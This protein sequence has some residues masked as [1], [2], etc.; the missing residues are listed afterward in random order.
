MRKVIS[1]V[2][3]FA[4]LTLT[5]CGQTAP[6]AKP[7]QDGETVQ[8]APSVEPQQG[9][10]TVQVAN[11]WRSV[12]EAEAK[13][14]CP[15]S[16][17]APDGAENVQWRAMESAEK[18]ALVQLSFELT[19]YSYT[20]REQVTN[21]KAADISGMHYTW[22]AQT[23]MT[24]Q[25]WEESAKSGTYYRCIGEGEWADLCAWY[26]TAKGISYSLGVTAK[27]LDGFDLEAIAEM[28]TTP[29]AA[30]AETGRQD[31][32]RFESVIIL[33]GME[34][35]VHYEHIRNDT[36]GFEMDYDYESFVRRKDADR[37]RFISVWDDP[38]NPENYLEV[39]RS[40][41]D[42]ETAAAEICER[43]SAEYEVRRD[44]AYT[45][46][47][48]GSCILIYADEVKG[49]GY[50]PD[51]LQ[52]VYVIPAG[53]GCCIATEHSYIVESE[54]FGR[55]FRYMMDTLAV[56]DRP[57][58]EKLSDEQALAAVRRY[59]TVSNPELESIVNAGEYQAYWAIES[60]DTQK[61][62]VL[63]RSYTGALIRYYIDPVSGETYVTE[64]VSGITP[65]EQ[66][67]GEH[68]NARDFLISVP[69]TWQTASVVSEADGTAHPEYYV[70]FTDPEILYGHMR[71][72]TFVVDHAETISRFEKT[73][74]GGFRI[75]AE[76]A[77][78]AQ[79]TFQTSE[80]D[81]GVLEYFETWN[82]ADFPNSYRGGAS[83]SRCS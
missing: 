38:E 18:P 30:P 83:L 65:E 1:I 80:S 52:T 74:A 13:S 29:P 40:R 66:R 75:R 32:E 20:A 77:D 78:G 46:E 22:T 17:R 14:L 28:L 41:Q 61:I 11:P 64:F 82:E 23:A 37:E 67:T 16:L 10:E 15:G 57:A 70:R 50:M 5:A 76:A 24:L 3:L 68:F 19:G 58:E 54:G 60:S 35:T 69:G 26:D 25:N 45:L 59:C 79:Y 6:S 8:A 27:D 53:D 49:G 21:D 36:I 9:G 4:M 33:E 7:Q 73:A 43:L 12:T 48:A 56:T 39:S 34:E 44:D 2:L 31:G 42:A 63:F 81:D 62:V 51:H 72:G 71:D 55:R 47:K